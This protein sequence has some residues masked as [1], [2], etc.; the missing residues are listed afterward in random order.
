MTT[1]SKRF[2]GCGGAVRLPRDRVDEYRAHLEKLGVSGSEFIRGLVVK[3]LDD[4]KDVKD[5]TVVKKKAAV[6]KKTMVK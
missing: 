3:A 5:K 6:T 2:V 1:H 4:V